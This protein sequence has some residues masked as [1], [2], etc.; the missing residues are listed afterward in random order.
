[1]SAPTAVALAAIAAGAVG[2]AWLRFGLGL[3]LNPLHPQIPL[4][5][6]AANLIGGLLVG[7]ALAWFVR[8]PEVAPAWR[9]FAVTGFLG[10][11]TT[12]STFSVESLQLLQRGEA[13]WAL[14]HSALHLAGSLAA[15]AIG[16]RTLA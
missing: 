6:W 16:Y 11:L 4:G 15:A 5:T 12:F 13:G 10:A 2:G 8:H 1:V 7:A 14:L 3:W 9:L